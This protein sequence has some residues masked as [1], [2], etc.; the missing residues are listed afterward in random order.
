MLVILLINLEEEVIGKDTIIQKEKKKMIK[1]SKNIR[2]KTRNIAK[3]KSIIK[4]EIISLEK[5]IETTSIINTRKT[6]EIEKSK[7]KEITGTIMTTDTIKTTEIT[8]KVVEITEIIETIEILEII[9]TEEKT[10]IT[11]ITEK[12]IIEIT[13]AETEIAIVTINNQEKER[14]NLTR[15]VA[16]KCQQTY[17]ET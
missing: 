11:E 1:I 9:G 16:L 3:E 7:I 4:I 2:E 13:E 8:D 5:T 6:T 10:G 12:E 15:E 17:V 14:N